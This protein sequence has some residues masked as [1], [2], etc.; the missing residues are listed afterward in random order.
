MRPGDVAR[1]SSWRNA[2][3]LTGDC[4][5]IGIIVAT[6]AQSLGD[7]ATTDFVG[8][9]AP[10]LSPHH[11]RHPGR[12]GAACVQFIEE[13]REGAGGVVEEGVR[14]KVAI[15]LTRQMLECDP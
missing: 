2:H 5:P 8:R 6:A 11:R 3:P 4:A 10:T 7:D 15:T 1:V 14:M 12:P 13:N 9:T